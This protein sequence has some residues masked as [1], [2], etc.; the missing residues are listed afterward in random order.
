MVN[1]CPPLAESDFE[2]ACDSV[3]NPAIHSSF[4]LAPVC[5]KE[6]LEALKFGKS[7]GVGLDG[8]SVPML[9]ASLPDLLS[10]LTSLVN[11]SLISASFPDDW[12]K[13]LIVPLSKIKS[14]ASESDTRPIALLPEPSKVV[15]RIVQQRLLGYL[16][17]HQLLDPRQAEFRP[18]HST[19]TAL[20][21]VL[22][23]VRWA[24]DKRKVTI[25]VLLDC[26]KAFDTIITIS[27]A[28]LLKKLRN[29][30]VENATLRWFFSYL[31]DRL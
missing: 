31:A 23:D 4:H 26:S 25:L 2:A 10:P 9:R 6:V 18:G 3:R 24:I 22:D 19:Q 27:H 30:N 1:K 11:N 15:E 17:A 8:L 21:G 14:P 16:E 13:A 12:E 28:R 7:K 29:F 20:L 5:E